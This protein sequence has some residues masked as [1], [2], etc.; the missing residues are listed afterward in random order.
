MFYR[1]RDN[2]VCDFSMS[3]YAQ[4]CIFTN[5]NII[6]ATDGRYYLQSELP[7]PTAQQLLQ[8]EKKQRT[9]AVS[10]IKVQVDGMLFDGDQISQDRM[11]RTISAAQAQGVDFNTTTR[12]WVLADN[13]VQNPTIAQLAKALRLA[14]DEQTLLWTIPY[15]KDESTKTLG[16]RKVGL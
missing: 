6:L 12:T 1:K 15:A 5:E 8:Q 9:Q 11:S 13:T 2:Y 14:G 16:L 3:Q 10:K 4:D 7:Q